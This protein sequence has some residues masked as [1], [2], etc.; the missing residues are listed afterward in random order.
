MLT[1]M[2]RRNQRHAWGRMK[3]EASC[4]NATKPGG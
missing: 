2:P 4:N 3:V 1:V